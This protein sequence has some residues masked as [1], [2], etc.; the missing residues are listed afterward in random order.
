MA[1]L[2]SVDGL[3]V[4]YGARGDPVLAVRDVTFSIERNEV[5]GLIGESGSGKSS[6]LGALARACSP[7]PRAPTPG[8]SGSRTKSSPCARTRRSGSCAGGGS[9]SCPSSR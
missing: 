3:T 6:V 5:F 9:R 1:P 8:R 2:L 4:T 7:P